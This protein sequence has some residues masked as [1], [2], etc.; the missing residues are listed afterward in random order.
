MCYVRPKLKVIGHFVWRLC[1]TYFKAWVNCLLLKL[2][3]KR[4]SQKPQTGI[5]PAATFWSP[6]RHSNHW[7]TGTQMAER[8]LRCVLVRTCDIRTAN[9]A[10]SICLCIL[11]TDI[12]AYRFTVMRCRDCITLLL[13]NSDKTLDWKTVGSP[14]GCV[15]P[16]IGPTLIQ[17]CVWNVG[18]CSCYAILVQ[19]IATDFLSKS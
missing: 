17:V 15:C 12:Q 19:T 11:L 1:K 2:N 4:E 3:R 16:Y 13:V 18:L 7:G 14:T 9:T 5:E 10:V 8:R 6:V